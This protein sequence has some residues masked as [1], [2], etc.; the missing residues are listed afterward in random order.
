MQLTLRICNKWFKKI[1]DWELKYELK[2][3]KPYWISRFYDK[4]WKLKEY[5]IISIK[6]GY[7]ATSPEVIVEFDWVEKIIENNQEYFKVKL[8]KIIEVKNYLDF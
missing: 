6:N 5:K 8:W 7:S 4:T 1:L 3:I 2:E